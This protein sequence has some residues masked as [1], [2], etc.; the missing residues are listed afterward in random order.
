MRNGIIRRLERDRI[1]MLMKAGDLPAW[2]MMLLGGTVIVTATQRVPAATMVL[3][4]V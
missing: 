1:A 2:S 3:R 4:I